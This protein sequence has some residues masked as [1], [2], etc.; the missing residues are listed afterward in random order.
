MFDPVKERNFYNG[1]FA[2]SVRAIGA[3]QDRL[4]AIKCVASLK[5]LIEKDKNDT[6]ANL[7][8]ALPADCILTPTWLTYFS[9]YCAL[10][11]YLHLGIDLDIPGKLKQARDISSD[12][13]SEMA[14]GD[15]ELNDAERTP[16]TDDFFKYTADVFGLHHAKCTQIYAAIKTCRMVLNG[17][18]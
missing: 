1:S 14:E 16:I 2:D 7:D 3:H 8:K 4:R 15:I 5:G 12:A 9:A 17:R 10:E 18:A 6:K 13:I 11:G